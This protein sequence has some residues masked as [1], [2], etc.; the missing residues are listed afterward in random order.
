MNDEQLDQFDRENLILSLPF[1]GLLLWPLTHKTEIKAQLVALSLYL[2]LF[3]ILSFLGLWALDYI[4]PYFTSIF[5][6]FLQRTLAY[7]SS[8]LLLAHFSLH[9]VYKKDILAFD[10]YRRILESR[11]LAPLARLF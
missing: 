3:F 9:W 5:V 8:F 1:V 7:F 10:W 4:T 11:L 6:S 2:H